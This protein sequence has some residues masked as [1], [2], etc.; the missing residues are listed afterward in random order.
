MTETQPFKIPESALYQSLPDST[1]IWVYQSNRTFSGEE[2][3]ALKTLLTRFTE[4]WAS[5]SQQL[6]AFADVLFDRFIILMADESMAGASG[7]SIDA[8]VRFLQQLEKHY[9][10]ELFDRMTFAWLDDGEVKTAAREEFARLY[11]KGAID[12]E[13]QVF[14]NLVKTKGDF[15]KGWLKPLGKSWHK[16]MV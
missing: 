15:E 7:C 8:S 14:D 2:I 11:A 13:T 10:V 3:P 4:G 5:H 9:G 16:R 12:D 6:S 1:R